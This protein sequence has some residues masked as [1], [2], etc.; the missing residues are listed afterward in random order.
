[1]VE[2]FKL[3]LFLLT[4]PYPWCFSTCMGFKEQEAFFLKKKKNEIT[5]EITLGFLM[6]S[7]GIERNRWHEK[8]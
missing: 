1:M 2:L 6:F 3:E 4:T 8:G 7:G 5:N